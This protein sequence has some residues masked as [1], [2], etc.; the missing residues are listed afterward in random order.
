MVKSHL[1]RKKRNRESKCV[2]LT[3]NVLPTASV[4]SIACT[5]SA[6]VSRSW[7]CPRSTVPGCFLVSF[8]RLFRRLRRTEEG[9]FSL[10]GGRGHV[11]TVVALTVCVRSTS[12]SA[13]GASE[14]AQT[15]W[16][17]ERQRSLIC[18]LT[19]SLKLFGFMSVNLCLVSTR[20]KDRKLTAN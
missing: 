15:H 12:V 19:N 7:S 2:F 16:D 4:T 6:P 20:D 3:V 17:C 13:S 9:F 5:A 8:F 11:F 10:S 1:G 14:A 18:L